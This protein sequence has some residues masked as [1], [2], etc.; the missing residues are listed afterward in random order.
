MSIELERPTKSSH[1]L[2]L[3]ALRASVTSAFS[4]FGTSHI[5]PSARW[6]GL[7]LAS[8]ESVNKI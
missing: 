1:P 4:G 3:P 2:S 7:V 6:G 8:E 5:T